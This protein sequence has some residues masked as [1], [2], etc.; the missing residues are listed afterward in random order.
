MEISISRSRAE[1]ARGIDPAASEGW[2]GVFTTPGIQIRVFMEVPHGTT[3]VYLTELRPVNPA[4]SLPLR[5]RYLSRGL[6]GKHEAA[7]VAAD[8]YAGRKH[9]I[10]PSLAVAAA[11]TGASPTEVW[12]ALRRQMER[13]AILSGQMPLVPSRPHKAP[14][15]NGNGSVSDAELLQIVRSVGVAR[16]L[17]AAVAI[18]AAQ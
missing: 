18:E 6:K 9:L 13:A 2:P 14:A 11:I 4:P 15:V 12:W 3:T 1:I 8:L 10:E 5:G 17:D 16:V 7:F